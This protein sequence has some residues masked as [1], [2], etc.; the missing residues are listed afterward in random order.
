MN[1]IK[2]PPEI[3]VID[4]ILL[5]DPFGLIFDLISLIYSRIRFRNV[6]IIRIPFRV[7]ALKSQI[8]LGKGAIIGKGAK[9]DLLQKSSVVQ[10]GEN[11]VSGDNLSVNIISK[12]VVGNNVLLSRNVFII[13]HSHGTYGKGIN[14]MPDVPPVQRDLYFNPIEI[15]DNVWIG[16]S[17][18]IL[19]GVCIGSGSIINAGCIVSTDI[20]ENSIVSS[21]PS[22]ITKKYDSENLSWIKIE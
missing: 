17:V 20:P 9:I 7:N 3:N 15:G 12:L 1:K 22:K 4:R 2:W 8:K 18:K 13:D 16:E 21:A 19:K 5:K 10:I 14:E 11:F 6:K